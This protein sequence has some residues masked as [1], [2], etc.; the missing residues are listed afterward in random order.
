[1]DTVLEKPFSKNGIN[2]WVHCI[3]INLK[4]SDDDWFLYHHH[5]YIELL[6]GCDTD[7]VV[8][9][10]GKSY[11]FKSNDLVLINSKEPHAVIANKDSHYICIKVLP[12]ILYADDESFFEFKYVVPFMP[13]R[14]H[15]NVFTKSELMDIQTHQ[16]ISEIISEW[17]AESPAYELIIR[18]NL[19]KIFAGIFRYW[20][21]NNISLPVTDYSDAIKQALAYTAE[22]YGSVTEDEVADFCGLS[23]NYFSYLFRKETNRNFKDY[24]LSIRLREAEN[25]LI[26]TTDSITEIALL[27]GFSTASHFISKFKEYK[28]ITPKQFRDKAKRFNLP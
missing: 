11:P 18:A 15:Q 4:K 1:M 21:R 8:W 6:Y 5:D 19:L 13:E 14:S 17:Y 12:S 3:D 10:N 24:L 7:A 2:S 22:N 23:Y 25:K 27:C 28:K 16:L 26:S 20:N 9:I